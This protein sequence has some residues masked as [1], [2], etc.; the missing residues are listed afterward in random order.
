MPMIDKNTVALLHFDDSTNIL[1]DEIGKFSWISYGSINLGQGK[2]NDALLLDATSEKYFYTEKD[3][4]ILDMSPG[5]DF[6]I[7]FWFSCITSRSALIFSSTR[8]VMGAVSDRDINCF[9]NTNNPSNNVTN[10]HIL[11]TKFNSNSVSDPIDFMK[12]DNSLVSIT[13]PLKLLYLS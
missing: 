2:F 3:Y 8:K 1:K 10:L 4:S 11:F 6:T 9:V 13:I 5:N 7:D 12:A